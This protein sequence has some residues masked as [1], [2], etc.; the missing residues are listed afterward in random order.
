MSRFWRHF[1]SNGR[2]SLV[3]RRLGLFGHGTALPPELAQ[4]FGLAQTRGLR[5]RLIHGD[6]PAEQ[7]GVVEDD[8]LVSLAE[9]PVTSLTKL[10]RLLHRLPDGLHLPVVVLRGTR[11]F[12]RWVILNE[13]RRV[14]RP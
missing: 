4:R 5:V 13:A 7:A 2:S 10:Y 1:S 8:I 3:E 11:R 9:Q 14:L 6:G 12:E